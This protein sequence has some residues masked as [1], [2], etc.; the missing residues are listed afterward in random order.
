VT[1]LGRRVPLLVSVALW[2]GVWELVGRSGYSMI[3][4]PFSGVV[5]AG[6][7]VVQTEK[8]ARAVAITAQG[9]ALGMGLA[10]LVGVPL[11]VLMA[12]VESARQVLGPWVN[13]LVSAP[14]SA[15]VPIL[16]AVLGI[17]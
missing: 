2:F 12:R 17:G 4:P 8:F 11:G 10:L 3:V 16:M 6:V 5:A 7:A 13:A 1:I 15:L 9:F 14:I